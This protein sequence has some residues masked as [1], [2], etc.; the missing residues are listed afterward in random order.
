MRTHAIEIG[1]ITAEDQSLFYQVCGIVNSLPDGLNC[2]EVCE[3]ICLRLPRLE[4]RTGFFCKC[5]VEHSWLGI[6]DSRNVIIDP[7]P[8]AGSGP[9]MITTEGLL[10]PWRN[11][12]IEYNIKQKNLE[13]DDWWTQQK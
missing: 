1:D 2:H 6:I 9:F 11:I 3:E 13:Y 8:V 12:Y 7:Y 10:N 4:L 5:G